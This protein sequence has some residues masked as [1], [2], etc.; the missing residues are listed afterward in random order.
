MTKFNFKKNVGSFMDRCFDIVKKITDENIGIEVFQ[1]MGTEEL[2][3][4]QESLRLVK[5][6]RE[7][8]D[9]MLRHYD[10]LEDELEQAKRDREYMMRMLKE[11]TK[12]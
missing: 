3:M 10:E 12:K 4:M 1:N 5:D 8:M 9:D 7:L 2:E 6:G 11:L